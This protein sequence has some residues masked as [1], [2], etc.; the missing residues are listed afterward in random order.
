MQDGIYVTS[1]PRRDLLDDQ[2]VVGDDECL[3][4]VEPD[5]ERAAAM[6]SVSSQQQWA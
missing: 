4:Q 1:Q 6:S 5:A 3:L 2:Q